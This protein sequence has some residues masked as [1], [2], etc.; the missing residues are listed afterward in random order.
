MVLRPLLAGSLWAPCGSQF[1]KGLP[2]KMSKNGSRAHLQTGSNLQAAGAGTIYKNGLN[3]DS[4]RNL[5]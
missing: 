5:I 3:M 2:L 1:E 4:V